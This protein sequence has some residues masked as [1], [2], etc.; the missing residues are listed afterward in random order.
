V[1]EHG[2]IFYLIDLKIKTKVGVLGAIGR[3]S[4]LGVIS[5]QLS[6]IQTVQPLQIKEE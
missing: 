4:L 1:Q 2:I 6:Q 5:R 3:L